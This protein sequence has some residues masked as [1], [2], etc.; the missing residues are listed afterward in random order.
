MPWACPAEPIRQGRIRRRAPR[1]VTRRVHP[2]PRVRRWA[3]FA[4]RPACSLRLAS[5]P[6]QKSF[7]SCVGR[8]A[9]V[10]AAELRDRAAARRALDEAELQ[11]VRLVDVL[12]RVLLLAERRRERRQADRAAV[13]L[14]RDRAQQ[15]AR[16][17]VEALLVDLEQRRAPRARSRS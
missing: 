11:Q 16:L 7:A 10:R 14:A 15:L 2:R 5:V 4:S 12:D 6:A 17:A 13:E 8:R 1:T 9:D 3:G